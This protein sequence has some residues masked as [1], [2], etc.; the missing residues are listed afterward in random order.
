MGTTAQIGKRT[1]GVSGDM[2][3]L[4]LTDQF[5]LIDLASVAEHLEGILL[6]DVGATDLLLALGE[7]EHFLL[8]LGKV[9]GC[10]LV[11]SRINIIIETCLYGRTDAEFHS[12]IKFLE[13]FCEKMGRR[14]P[15]SML[16]FGIIPFE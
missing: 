12:G 9:L 8:D 4:K 11:F 10:D 14:M 13:C 15:E 3:V 16:A 6:G 1:L 2:S 7:L 5:T